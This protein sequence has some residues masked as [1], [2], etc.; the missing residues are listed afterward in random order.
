MKSTTEPDNSH[1]YKR[2]F[3]KRKNL[4]SAGLLNGDYLDISFRKIFAMRIWDHLS[5]FS[6]ALDI[7]FEEEQ[8]DF[9]SLFHQL[10]IGVRISV[11]TGAG[12]IRTVACLLDMDSAWN[13]VSKSVLLRQWSIKTNSA[14]FPNE[15]ASTRQPVHIE[16]VI[17]IFGKLDGLC[18]CA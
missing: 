3:C 9:A 16:D 1:H 5:K 12:K 6:Y 2:H 10:S 4:W 18:V 11:G 7:V 17:P 14:D 13:Q 8:N 15:Q